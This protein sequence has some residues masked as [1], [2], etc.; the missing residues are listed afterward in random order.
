MFTEGMADHGATGILKHL[1]LLFLS[2]Y[3][4]ARS[5]GTTRTLIVR[6]GLLH[7]PRKYGVARRLI[8]YLKVP[9]REFCPCVLAVG[10]SYRGSL[11]SLAK[12]L[13]R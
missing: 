8:G 12:D 5:L 11:R 13:W 4:E 3:P 9:N 6:T 1:V 7:I 10:E 2:L